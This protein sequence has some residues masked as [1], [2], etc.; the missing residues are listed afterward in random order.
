MD[1]RKRGKCAAETIRRGLIGV[2]SVDRYSPSMT[3]EKGGGNRQGKRKKNR[4][5]LSGN[6]LPRN[7]KRGQRKKMIQKLLTRE[8]TCYWQSCVVKS[9]VEQNLKLLANR[10]EGPNGLTKSTEGP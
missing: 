1:Q 10:G 3:I 2:N 5:K 4:S 6:W 9:G 7:V 8:R